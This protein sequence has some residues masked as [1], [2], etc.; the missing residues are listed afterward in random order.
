MHYLIITSFKNVSKGGEGRDRREV[1]E[2]EE[3]FYMNSFGS[4]KDWASSHYFL[5]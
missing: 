5:W 2:E 4:E 3:D 1:R